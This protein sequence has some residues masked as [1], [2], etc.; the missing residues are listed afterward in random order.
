[1]KKQIA[2]MPITVISP[3]RSL[4]DPPLGHG[5]QLKILIKKSMHSYNCDQ[6]IYY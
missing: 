5:V 4:I 3:D 2:T 1:M 6:L